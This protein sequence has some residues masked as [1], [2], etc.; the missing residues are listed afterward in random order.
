MLTTQQL[1]FNLTPRFAADV[2]QKFEAVPCENR[3][4]FR[5]RQTHSRDLINI[6]LASS[7][8]GSVL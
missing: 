7:P 2:R 5:T 8:S 4:R 1:C 6:F 3:D